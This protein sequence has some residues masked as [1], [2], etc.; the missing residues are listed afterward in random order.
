[1]FV[2]AEKSPKVMVCYE[3]AL[4]WQELFD[5][6]LR[7]GTPNSDIISMGYHVAGSSI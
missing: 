3:K 1:V 7:E 4:E 5:L 2:E 6:A